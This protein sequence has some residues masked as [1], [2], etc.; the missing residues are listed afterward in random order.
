DVREPPLAALVLG[1]VVE[2]RRDRLNL[3]AAG[4]EN[5]AA[6]AKEMRDVRDAAPLAHLVAMD[7]GGIDEGF[8]EELRKGH[9]INQMQFRAGGDN[10][11]EA[12]IAGFKKVSGKSEERFE[13][14][15]PLRSQD[16]ANLRRARRDRGR[17]QAVLV[18]KR[19]ILSG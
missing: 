6:D 15:K 3:A 2:K 8:A 16:R 17:E 10:P 4:S 9:D 19:P 18:D 1:S 7:R 5:S 12:Q 13:A 11:I 14:F